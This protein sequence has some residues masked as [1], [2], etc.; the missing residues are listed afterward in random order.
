MII[1]STPGLTITV[2]IDLHSVHFT[3]CV[4]LVDVGDVAVGQD[5]AHVPAFRI[6]ANALNIRKQ[7]IR[8]RCYAFKNIFAKKIAK[9][10]GVFDS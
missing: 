1:T 10:L 7:R 8:D 9:K 5:L 6:A 4:E 2:R 3:G